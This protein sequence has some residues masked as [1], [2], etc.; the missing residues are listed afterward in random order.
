MRDVLM[1]V[2]GWLFGL[3]SP[4]IVDEVRRHRQKSAIEA[5]I[6]AELSE[7]R[8]RLAGSVWMIASR[9][10][11]YDRD[12]LHWMKRHTDGYDGGLPKDA[13]RR[14]VEAQLNLSDEQFAAVAAS[15]RADG[16]GG[17]TVKRVEVPFIESKLGELG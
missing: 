8:Y 1:L 7:L 17:L 3:L 14:A 5:G 11:P 9:F 6:R 10:G 13:L 12:L 4:L 16:V 15:T 2:L